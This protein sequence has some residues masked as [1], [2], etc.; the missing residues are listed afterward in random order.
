MEVIHLTQTG[1]N[2]AWH[3]VKEYVT[4]TGHAQVLNLSSVDVTVA[5]S[6]H[7]LTLCRVLR[8]VKVSNSVPVSFNLAII[9]KLNQR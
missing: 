8:D 4:D 6:E 1:P 7:Q 5:I 2:V 3:V 9:M